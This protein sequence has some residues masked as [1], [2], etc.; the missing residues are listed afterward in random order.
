MHINLIRLKTSLM[1]AQ[2][3]TEILIALDFEGRPIDELKT[4]GSKTTLQN[5]E[6]AV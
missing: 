1:T 3:G 5:R 4:M 6:E 2:R